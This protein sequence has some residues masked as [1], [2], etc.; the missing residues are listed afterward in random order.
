MKR[1]RYITA[2]CSLK[3]PICHFRLVSSR[4]IGKICR[5]PGRIYYRIL[6][7]NDMVLKKFDCDEYS[8]TDDTRKIGDLIY[9]QVVTMWNGKRK[10][11]PY[12]VDAEEFAEEQ[13]KKMDG[14]VISR[15]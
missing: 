3:D 2:K 10:V 4:Y 14:V 6:I 13:N 5:E 7:P 11:V 8:T 12:G 1:Y 9:D 15:L